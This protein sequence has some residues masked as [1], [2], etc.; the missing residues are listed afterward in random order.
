[1]SPD[2]DDRMPINV[3]ELV[4]RADAVRH[5]RDFRVRALVAAIDELADELLWIR[6]RYVEAYIHNHVQE[7]IASGE[8]ENYREDTA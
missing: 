4:Y 5:V 8:I 2:P 7:L 1:M 3:P 6:R